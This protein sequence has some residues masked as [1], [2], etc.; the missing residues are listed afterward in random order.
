MS[1]EL[2]AE[3]E[4]ILV[5]SQGFT[6]EASFAQVTAAKF[7]DTYATAKGVQR[8]LLN[9]HAALQLEQ[10]QWQQ[11]SPVD[12]GGVKAKVFTSDHLDVIAK[13]WQ[14]VE[15]KAVIMTTVRSDEAGLSEW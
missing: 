14:K 3:C 8:H 1:V 6:T 12:D 4:A 2:I 15:Q 9:L 13:L 5:R 10:Q 7:T 11:S